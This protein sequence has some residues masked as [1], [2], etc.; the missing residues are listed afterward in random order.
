VIGR[1]PVVRALLVGT[2]GLGLLLVLSLAFAS[3]SELDALRAD[4]MARWSPATETGGSLQPPIV[5]AEEEGS[6]S[7]EFYGPLPTLGDRDGAIY[8]RTF[9]VPRVDALKPF[10]A[11]RQAALAAGWR[12][13]YPDY[14]T[15][16]SEPGRTSTSVWGRKELPTGDA[17]V[18]ITLD[19]APALP[20]ISPTALEG[21]SSLVVTLEHTR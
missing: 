13:D 2:V 3:D 6:P 9:L 14:L 19:T 20:G 7:I 4:P 1:R 17:L 18:D 21:T 12:L 15:E 8:M 16:N 10:E 11:A 5:V